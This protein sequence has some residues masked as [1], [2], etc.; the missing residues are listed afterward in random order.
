MKA[1][2]N[3]S[4]TSLSSLRLYFYY[5]A[6]VRGK[7]FW[8]KLMAPSLG[9]KLAARAKELEISQAILHRVSAGYLKG[10]PLTFDGTEVPPHKLP[11]CLELVDEESKLRDFLSANAELLRGVRATLVRCSDPILDL[12]GSELKAPGNQSDPTQAP[13]AG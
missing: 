13:P 4:K 11:Q 9:S 12:W 2:P 5:G 8:Q 10:D 6:K 1:G 3:G 7:T